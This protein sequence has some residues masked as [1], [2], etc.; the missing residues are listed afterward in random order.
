MVSKHIYNKQKSDAWTKRLL[1]GELDPF[2]VL[3]VEVHATETEL[4]K[5][6][7]QLAVQVCVHPDKNK[8][9]RAGEAFKVLRALAGVLGFFHMAFTSIF[10]SLKGKEGSKTIKTYKLFKKFTLIH[11]L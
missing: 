5:A 4:K 1:E 6:Y 11:T 2:T 7:R 9:P 8:H 3:G 10:A